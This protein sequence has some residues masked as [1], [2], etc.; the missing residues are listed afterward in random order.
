MKTFRFLYYVAAIGLLCFS[1]SNSPV[2]QWSQWRGPNRDGVSPE[3]NLLKTWPAE[4]PKLAWSA[5]SLGD[6]FSSA[7]I[8]N[9][10]VYVTG[11]RDSVEILT[12][13][14]LNGNLKWQK[15]IG[16]ASEEKDWPQS[17]CTPTIYENKVYTIT[18]R[19]DMACL[20]SKSGETVWEM[21]AFERFEGL[22]QDGTAE[23]PLVFDDKVIVTPGGSKT[24]MVAL[25]RLTGKTVWESESLN[26]SV[27]FT[28]P[29]LVQTKNTKAIFTSTLHYDIFVDGNTGKI[30]WKGDHLSGMVP[31]VFNNQV[32]FSGE[33][34]KTGTLCSWDENLSERTTVWN[35]TILGNVLGGGVLFNDRLAISGN[36]RGIFCLDLKT[37]ET[38]SKYDSINYCNLLVAD[39]R[40][41]AYEDKVGKVCLFA[42]AGDNLDLVSSFRMSLGT[43]P[44]IAHLSI[45][46]GVLYIRRGNVLAA[47]DIKQQ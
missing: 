40:L 14:D 36:N 12:A 29:I 4:G 19:G 25:D 22:P 11:K 27:N 46:D 26:D 8:Y 18:V 2:S 33:Y 10:M 13:L 20:D 24:T 42:L 34:Q 9:R 6:G 15:V 41:Y 16:R 5:D 17:R 32:Y 31:L 47:Y 7:S 37:G 21:P 38:L 28:S 39:G 45:S 23:S 1:C 43:G 35:D 30:I 3:K 44:R